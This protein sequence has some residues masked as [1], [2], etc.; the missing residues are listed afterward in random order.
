MN[1]SANL[2]ISI[3]LDGLLGAILDSLPSRVRVN[4]KSDRGW[5]AITAAVE[6]A[7]SFS[8]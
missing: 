5:I 2:A 7:F 6:A 4:E 1:I 3:S 8:F